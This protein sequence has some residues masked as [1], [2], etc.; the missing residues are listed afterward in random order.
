MGV[1][2]AFT[3]RCS[4]VASGDQKVGDLY[5]TFSPSRQHKSTLACCILA[6]KPPKAVS[7]VVDCSIITHV[8]STD[9][10]TNRQTN[11]QMRK[12]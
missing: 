6:Y 12:T 5:A 3:C 9:A 10:Q 4:E 1:P 8:I 11:K 2:Y 7:T